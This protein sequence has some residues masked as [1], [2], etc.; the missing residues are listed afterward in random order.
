MISLTYLCVCATES[1]FSSLDHAFP[2][3]LFYLLYL[4]ETDNL[5]ITGLVHAVN[6]EFSSPVTYKKLWFWHKMLCV[7][8]FL[9]KYEKVS[10]KKQFLTG[11]AI[12]KSHRWLD[13]F[14]VC[15]KPF[16]DLYL[17][18]FEHHFENKWL[19][20]YWILSENL[21]WSTFLVT[22]WENIRLKY[23]HSLNCSTLCGG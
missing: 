18:K 22:N 11:F 10:I 21:R 17:F 19:F 12:K 23:L 5:K 9:F 7:L 6:R 16:S 2:V 15:K 20:L 3:H 13:I 1:F 4:Q 14:Y 8:K